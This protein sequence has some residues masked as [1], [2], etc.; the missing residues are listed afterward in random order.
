MSGQGNWNKVEWTASYFLLAVLF[1]VLII[2]LG[3]V[4]VWPLPTLDLILSWI[5]FI[6]V[7]AAFWFGRKSRPVRLWVIGY[8][9]ATQLI[10]MVIREPVLLLPIVGAAIPVGIIVW[11]LIVL[12]KKGQARPSAGHS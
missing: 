1:T 5:A 12:S 2:R 6:A 7:T 3:F 11:A 8:G 4:S 9:A 10:P